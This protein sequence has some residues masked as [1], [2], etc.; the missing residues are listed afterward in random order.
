M[1]DPGDEPKKILQLLE[2]EQQKLG[3]PIQLKYLLH[4]HAHFDHINGTRGVREGWAPNSGPGGAASVGARILLHRGD[5]PLYANLKRQLEFLGLDSLFSSQP[6]GFREPLP[7]DEF[8]EDNQELRVGELKLTV[9]HTPGHSPGGVSIRL[10]EDSH[11]GAIES[12]FSGDSLFRGSIGR[13]DF[14]GSDHEQL[15]SSIRDRIFTLDDDTRVCPGHGPESKV[16]FEKRQ[17]PFFR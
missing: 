17:N 12:V 2:S 13:T 15:L 9:L 6:F 11:A 10:H 5:E 4:T 7:I 1:V 16:G 8:F 14:W 3:R